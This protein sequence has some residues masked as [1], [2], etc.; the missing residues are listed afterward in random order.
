MVFTSRN[1]W[2]LCVRDP[3]ASS[4][5]RLLA[6]RAASLE[7]PLTGLSEETDGSFPLRLTDLV[8]LP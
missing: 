3:I 5:K 8:G 7:S 2:H 4:N 1:S 6:G